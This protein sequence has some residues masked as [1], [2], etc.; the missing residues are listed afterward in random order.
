MIKR[1][2]SDGIIINDEPVN[3]NSNIAKL[4]PRT[5]DILGRSVMLDRTYKKL[6][7]TSFK[8][9]CEEARSA[10]DYIEVN[11]PKKFLNNTQKVRTQN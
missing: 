2:K 10:V 1:F 8:F 11:F 6:L 3:L 5:I 7:D 9:L 4:K